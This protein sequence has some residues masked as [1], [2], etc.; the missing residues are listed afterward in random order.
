MK[1]RHFKS[2]KFYISRDGGMRRRGSYSVGYSEALQRGLVPDNKTSRRKYGDLLDKV[3]PVEWHHGLA[4]NK[5]N[6]FRVEDL[7]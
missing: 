1:F 3:A 4:G 5:I 2:T 7:K 6:F